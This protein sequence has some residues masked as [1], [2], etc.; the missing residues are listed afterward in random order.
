MTKPD[1][2]QP[3]TGAGSDPAHSDNT[4]VRHSPSGESLCY[5]VVTAVAEA[6]GTD[7]MSLEPLSDTID[8]DALDQLFDPDPV[9]ADQAAT[10]SVT[11]HY[12]GSVVEVYADGQTV[13]SSPKNDR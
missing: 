12:E 5:G 8:P 11:F 6:T 3:V 1:S 4:S 2:H 7:P 10:G 13:V 9:D